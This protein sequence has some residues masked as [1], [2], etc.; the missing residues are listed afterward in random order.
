MNSNLFRIA[1]SVY[2]T[3][4]AAS[5]TA[6]AGAGT[7]TGGPAA[8]VPGGGAGSGAS[9]SPAPGASASAGPS[10][11]P[12]AGASAHPSPSASASASPSASP[13]PGTV[14]L[15]CDNAPYPSA[16][17]TQCEAT[18]Y[19]MT[20][21]ATSEQANATFQQRWSAQGTANTNEW[22]ARAQAD[23][24][25]LSPTSGNSA[26]TPLCATWGSQCAGD[27]FRYA[28][29]TGPDGS[30]FY[31]G[32]AVVTPVVFYDDGCARLSGR[33]WAPANSASGNRLPNVVIQNGSIQAPETLYWWAA[34]ML[35]REGYVVMTFDPRG[36]GR[37]D[38]QTPSGQAGSNLNVV[39]FWTGLVNAIDFFRSTPSTPYPWNATCAGTYPTVVTNY[40]PY[41]DRIDRNRLGIAGHSAGAVGVS[42]VQGYGGAGAAPWPGKIDATNPVKVAVAWDGLRA[43]AG[44]NVGGIGSNPTTGA[45]VP[46]YVARVPAMGNSSEYG[47][48]PMAFTSPPPPE[49]HKVGYGA[50]VAAGV[51]VYELTIRGS[52]HYEWSLLANFP[53]TSWCPNPSIG[54]CENGWGNP[55]AQHYTLAWFDRW[56]KQP[57]EAGYADADA[58]LL[59]D[60]GAQG[61][62]KMS[63]RFHS[64]RNYPDRGGALHHCE[65]IRAGCTPP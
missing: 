22:L 24:S 64:A 30:A 40:N 32:Q 59:D 13:S 7:A 35:V 28:D 10:A 48:T 57:G 34:Q 38:E 4:V 8:G 54:V 21:E 5:L 9:P 49:L 45:T 56:L 65:N 53:T 19:A 52:S 11:S 46:S 3:L 63:F 14:D 62:V 26:Q 61:R 37:S 55:M 33:V 31:S 23:P 29:F 43:P 36:Q 20:G 16:Q 47:L 27:P 12:S 15:T 17:W 1:S 39:V 18:N 60:N 42:V 6:C 2:A 41:W 51:P 50:W 44:G 25:W 58:R